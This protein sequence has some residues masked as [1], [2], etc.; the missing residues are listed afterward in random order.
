M[1]HLGDALGA[2]DAGRFLVQHVD[3]GA[4]PNGTSWTAWADSLE[5]AMQ[6]A[7]RIWRP[8]QDDVRQEIS[9]GEPPRVWVRGPG[10][11]HWTEIGPGP[12]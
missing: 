6:M 1:A 5:E 8:E 2:S 11:L 12:G 4:G 10:D 9:T 3:M 7:D